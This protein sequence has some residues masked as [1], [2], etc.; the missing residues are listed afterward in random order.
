VFNPRVYGLNASPKDYGYHAIKVSLY[1]Q[2]HVE[3]T[4]EAATEG[5]TAEM[6]RKISMEFPVNYKRYFRAAQQ[7]YVPVVA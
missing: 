1:A 3:S 7:M 5:Y 4:L 6:A 2:V